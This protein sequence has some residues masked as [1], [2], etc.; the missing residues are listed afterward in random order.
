MSDPMTNEERAL[1][2]DQLYTFLG[3]TANSGYV[4]CREVVLEIAKLLKLEKAV[5]K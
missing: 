4:D 5:V 1:R 2:L 3:H